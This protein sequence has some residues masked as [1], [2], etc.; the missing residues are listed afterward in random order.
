[1]MAGAYHL[2]DEIW[3]LTECGWPLEHVVV[4][5]EAGLHWQ[6]LIRDLAPYIGTF[7]HQEV[8]RRCDGCDHPCGYMA[9]PPRR[10]TAMMKATESV[11]GGLL[12]YC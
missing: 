7:W 11:C 9:K 4:R 8:A 3:L 5:A 1:M 6:M 12:Y 10:Q 2:A